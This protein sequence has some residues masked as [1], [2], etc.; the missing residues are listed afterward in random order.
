MLRFILILAAV[1]LPALAAPPVFYVSPG[2]YDDHDGLTAFRGDSLIAAP[3]NHGPFAT[4]TRARD[5]LRA[6]GLAE[7]G[8]VYVVAGD[9]YLNEPL[10]LEA[11]D[12]GAEGKPVIWQAYD[13]NEVYLHGGKPI[14]DDAFVPHHESIVKADIRVLKLG[15]QA[16][17]LI[18]RRERQV[19]ARWPNKGEGELPGGG[20]AFIGAQNKDAPMKS[21]RYDG[22]GPAAFAGKA[23]VEISIWPNYNWW[24]TIVGVDKIDPTTKLVHL[25]GD[26]PY[27]IEPGRRYFLQNAL[28]MLDAPGEWYHDLATQTLYLWPPAPLASNTPVTLPTAETVISAT[29]LKHAVFIGLNI[30]SSAGDGV[31][32]KNC[33]DVLFARAT[34][35][36]TYGFG[37]I[38]E[39]GQSVRIRGNDI[40][41]TGK[42]GITLNGGDRKTLTPG[43]HE[44]VNNHIHHYAQIFNTYN[45]G[46][47]IGGV[48]NRIQ[49]NNIHDAPHIGILLTGNDHLIEYND[50]HHVCLEGADNGGFYMGRDWT[51]RGNVI[52]YNKFHDIYGFGLGSLATN[53][54]GKYR[55]EAPHQAW[56]VYLDDCSSGTEIYGN[57]FY[58]VPLAG[59]MIG[60]GRDN[61]VHNN[62]FAECTPALHIDDRWDTY[63]WD[64]MR[65]RLEAMNYTQPP[66][67]ERYPELLTMGDDPRTPANNRF[68]R[69]VV[70][71]TRDN[72][73]GISTTAPSSGN[74]I[75]YNLAGFDPN[76]TVIKNNLIDLGGNPPRVYWR[77]YKQPEGSG[78]LSWEQWREK[79][80]DAG[81]LLTPAEFIDPAND[82]YRIKFHM[83]WPRTLKFKAIPADQ[84]GLYKDEFRVSWPVAADTRRDGVEHREW[85]VS[86]TP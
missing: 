50:I 59:V 48:G 3:S 1:A 72:F 76:T 79:G 66:Y 8:T 47:N 43:N 2:G 61:H 67:S 32:L 16:T 78:D 77:A 84:I 12:S 10:V 45:C 83:K 40:Y 31:V 15:K 25:P 85:H 20:W 73:R 23:G 69:N 19:L 81:S 27:T 58:R 17:Q 28:E 46:V 14:D 65:E 29:D 38:V 86:V 70:M 13:E 71:Y 49:H 41:A 82:D 21:F 7:G 30:E 54:E 64:L 9:H 22:D 62:I 24:Q 68:V 63:P 55:Y 56:G 18:L 44:A 57:I 60:G 6:A 34:V 36:N 35:R 80:F 75:L 37:V 5:A 26:L 4:L 42:G 39:G 11:Q 51:Q 74:G 52:R 53:A 33:T